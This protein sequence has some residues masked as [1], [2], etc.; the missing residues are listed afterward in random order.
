M[1]DE[2]FRRNDLRLP[3]TGFTPPWRVAS[4][5]LC[6]Q[7]VFPA[8]AVRWPARA[9]GYETSVARLHREGNLPLREGSCLGGGPSGNARF[10]T[11]ETGTST[12]RTKIQ[13]LVVTISTQAS[14]ALH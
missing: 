2:R 6:G 7:P 9:D 1:K 12:R 8:T 14:F 11:R 4:M 10:Q 5:N 13:R 3:S